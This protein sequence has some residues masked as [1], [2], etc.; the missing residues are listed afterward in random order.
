MKNVPENGEQR[1]TFGYSRG[2][3]ED[4]INL[5]TLYSL[6]WQPFLTCDAQTSGGP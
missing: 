4:I 2:A 3:V 5:H 1:K 6:L